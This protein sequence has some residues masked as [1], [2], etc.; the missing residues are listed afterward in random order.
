MP[1]SFLQ[2]SVMKKW[3]KKKQQHLNDFFFFF[4]Y[5]FYMVIYVR[6]G[7]VPQDMYQFYLGQ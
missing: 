2:N 1:F 3:E 6:D 7:V 4:V 5:V